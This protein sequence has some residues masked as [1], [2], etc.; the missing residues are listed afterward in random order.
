MIFVNVLILIVGLFCLIKGSQI[1]VKS[2]VSIAKRLGIST[3]II[4]LTII[5]FGTSLPELVSSIFASLE[6]AS[7]LIIG[8]IIGA[9]IANLSLINGIAS[10]INPIKVEK[11]VLKRD[12]YMV[13]FS[14]LILLISLIDG[15]ISRTEGI[16]FL[17]IYISY[18]LFLIEFKNLKRHYK[19]QDF[20]DY[21]FR[22][23][24]LHFIKSL[25]SKSKVSLKKKK[26]SNGKTWKKL[27]LLILGAV[28][29][30][31]GA[32][33][34]VEE[35]LFFAVSFNISGIII[36]VLISIGT[37]LPELSVS[38][39]ASR[40][41]LGNIVIGNTLGSCITNTLLILGISALI[42][43]LVFTKTTVYF[44]LGFLILTSFITLYFIKTR[45]KLRK[46]EGMFLLLI[47]VIFLILLLFGIF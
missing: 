23:G 24:Y 27:S 37:T 31:F 35:A 10:F 41:K 34:V 28:L 26:K 44:I 2:S 46:I 16:I 43:P 21:S 42:Y 15:K 19:F 36:G 17:L 12:G 6:K 30:Y 13:I 45:L 22:F 25:F 1:F 47:Y 40:K 39:T 4:G 18:I 5:A 8:T 14:V 33:Y 29:I 38:I 9:N 7:G 20:I 3:F 11:D 32:K